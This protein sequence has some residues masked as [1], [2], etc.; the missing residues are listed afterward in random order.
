MLIT[1][2]SVVLTHDMIYALQDLFAQKEKKKEVT[3]WP[4]ITFLLV[5]V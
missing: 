3:L 2:L 1:G 4:K 5:A